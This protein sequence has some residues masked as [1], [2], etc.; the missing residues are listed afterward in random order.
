MA[1]TQVKDAH[2]WIKSAV[3]RPGAMTA[4]AKREGISNSEFI[5]KY[6]G[7]QAGRDSPHKGQ[8]AGFAK[9]MRKI[10]S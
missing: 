9:N 4:A 10:N 2:K 1:V 8:M 7:T 3:K 6:A 5:Q